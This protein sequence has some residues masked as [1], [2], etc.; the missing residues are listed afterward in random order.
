M[1]DYSSNNNGDKAQTMFDSAAFNRAIAELERLLL[2][3]GAA[4]IDGLEQSKAN[5]TAGQGNLLI[6]FSYSDIVAGKVSKETI[7]KYWD[8]PKFKEMIVKGS[9]SK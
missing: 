3:S 2:E 7:A 6:P 1:S 9:K 4:A 5:G 8:N